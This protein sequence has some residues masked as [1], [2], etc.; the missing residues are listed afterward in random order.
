MLISNEKIS[1]VSM[2]YC[3]Q[4]NAGTQPQQAILD[5]PG[6]CAPCKQSKEAEM[7]LMFQ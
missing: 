2:G 6:I 7:V 1:S 4:Q 5:A 3:C